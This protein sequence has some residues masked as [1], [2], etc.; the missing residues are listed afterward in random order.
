MCDDVKGT[1]VSGYIDSFFLYSNDI[2]TGLVKEKNLEG[3]YFECQV[4]KRLRGKE[5][6]F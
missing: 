1:E 4:V 2:T 5:E 6:N 3:L